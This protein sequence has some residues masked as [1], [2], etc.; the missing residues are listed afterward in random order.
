MTLLHSSNK[1]FYDEN[2]NEREIFRKVKNSHFFSAIPGQVDFYIKKKKIVSLHSF[3]IHQLFLYG[4]WVS[5]KYY[6]LF[7]GPISVRIYIFFL[8]LLIHRQP[9]RLLAAA[10]MTEAIESNSQQ[11]KHW[12]TS[13]ENPILEFCFIYFFF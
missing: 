9:W 8:R 10:T 6:E 12:Q 13:L 2:E 4:T 11:K 3:I 5:N 7:L 1:H